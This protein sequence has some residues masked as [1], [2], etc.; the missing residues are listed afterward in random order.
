MIRI[1]N[2]ETNEIIDREMTDAEFA[3]V[4]QRQAAA[5]AQQAEAAAKEAARQALLEKLGITA[6]EAQ[7]LLG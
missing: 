5:E 2:T 3:K 1:H 6:E 7:L 4:Q